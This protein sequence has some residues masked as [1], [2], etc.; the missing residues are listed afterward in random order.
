MARSP[1]EFISACLTCP[2]ADCVGDEDAR[3]ALNRA[4]RRHRARLRIESRRR[5]RL[6]LTGRVLL[7]TAIGE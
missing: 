5:C 4:R 3:C 7:R 2:L 1:L 6:R